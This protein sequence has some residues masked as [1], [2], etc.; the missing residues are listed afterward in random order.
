VAFVLWC[1]WS[2]KRKG[3]QESQPAAS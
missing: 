2:G 1:L 3:R